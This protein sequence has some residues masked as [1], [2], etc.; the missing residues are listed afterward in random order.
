MSQ[1]WGHEPRLYGIWNVTRVIGIREK[2]LSEG[3]VPYEDLVET[4]DHVNAT[5]K[6]PVDMA[7][8]FWGIGD[9]EDQI[10]CQTTS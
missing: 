1:I 4:T 10:L 6:L 2:F 8:A 5:D 9:H 7:F 3:P